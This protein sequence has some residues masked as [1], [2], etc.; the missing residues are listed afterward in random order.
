[1]GSN[2]VLRGGYVKNSDKEL[3][4]YLMNIVYQ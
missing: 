2:A 3:W 1:M 4:R